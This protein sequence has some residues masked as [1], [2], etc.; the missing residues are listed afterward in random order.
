MLLAICR[1][2]HRELAPNHICLLQEWLCLNNS[3]NNSQTSHL[4]HLPKWLQMFR[5]EVVQV[6]CIVLLSP[7]SRLHLSSTL[8]TVKLVPCHRDHRCPRQIR[9]PPLLL[10]LPIC[11][12][13]CHHQDLPALPTVYKVE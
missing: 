6:Q 3:N 9:L 12:L 13:Q 10:L 4:S 2:L 8:P 7:L 11:N 5:L 1:E